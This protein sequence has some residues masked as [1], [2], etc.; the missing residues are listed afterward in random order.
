MKLKL[1]GKTEIGDC[2]K[3][4]VMDENITLFQAIGKKQAK[5]TL[6][7]VI[8][9]ID[10]CRTLDELKQKLSEALK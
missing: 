9:E 6:Q 1:V 5:L 4:W 7:Q 3:V 2:Y 10:Y 8:D